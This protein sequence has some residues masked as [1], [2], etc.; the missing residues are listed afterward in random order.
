MPLF[1]LF[2][3]EFKKIIIRKCMVKN[4]KSNINLNIK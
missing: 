4:E 1:P 3:N 2:I